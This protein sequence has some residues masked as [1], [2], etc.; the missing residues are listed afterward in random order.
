MSWLARLTPYGI[1][2]LLSWGFSTSWIAETLNLL[3]YDSSLWVKALPSGDQTAVRLIGINEEDIKRFGWPINDQ[4]LARGLEQLRKAQPRAIGLDLYRDHAVP[5]GSKALEQ[6]IKNNPK[7]IGIFSLADEINPPPAMPEL[8]QSFNDLVIDQ[9]GGLRRDLVH[10]G[11]QPKSHVSLPLRILEAST[12]L[13]LQ[14]AI[15]NNDWN[16]SFIHPQAGGYSHIDASGYQRMLPFHQPGSFP[17]WSLGD[18]LDGK[19]DQE[20]LKG[21]IV[22]VGSTAPSLRDTFYTPFSRFNSEQKL[23]EM[24]GVE[25]H[26]H[27]VAAL[28]SAQQLGDR[29]ITVMP[30][31]WEPVLLLFISLIGVG[32][33]EGI[34]SLQRSGWLLLVLEVVLLGAGFGL[35]LNGL[36]L[37][38]SSLMLTLAFI[39][40]AGWL[41]R[42]AIGQLHRRQIERLLGQ[43]TSPAVARELWKQRESLL[44]RGSFPGRTLQV[45]V[46][47]ADVVGFSSVAEKFTAAETLNWLNLGMSQFANEVISNGGM[48]NKFTGDGFLAVFGV[49]I[50]QDPQTSAN[51]A[52]MCAAKLQ[53]TVHTL[54]QTLK[55]IGQPSLKL[56]IGLHSGEAIAG[57]M[58]SSER[59]EFAVIGDVVNV[60]ARLEALNKERMTSDCRVLISNETRTLLPES[61]RKNLM[62][63]GLMAVK[64]RSQPVSVYE[65]SFDSQ[66]TGNC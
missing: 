59:M 10:V 51:Q 50:P 1:A 60:C 4:L 18:L 26:A 12:G 52:I 24:P 3:L 40:I 23:A 13:P 37:D 36:W 27:R 7:L 46:L 34:R 58:G 41:R 55:Q 14:E 31:G 29:G 64:G 6:A 17:T 48:V 61:Q 53:R 62:S 11:K 25:V 22:L 20:E 45:T 30:A 49:P 63:W 5:P 2:A 44:D 39:T 38:I 9:D 43:A 56:R 16:L 15:E 47:F 35:L 33:G 32:L 57:S 42:G 66:V 28:I 21:R 19:V 65:L 8:Q 54:Q